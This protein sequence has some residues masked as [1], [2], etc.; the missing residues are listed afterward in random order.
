[1]DSHDFVYW[2]GTQKK[3]EPT[4]TFSHCLSPPCPFP[5]LCRLKLPFH[6]WVSVPEIRS[7]K[8]TLAGQICLIQNGQPMRSKPWGSRK[9]VCKQRRNN[10]ALRL[11]SPLPGWRPKWKPA[12][13]WSLQWPTT[14][15]LN[16][17]E[18][19]TMHT[20]Q[21]APRC[22]AMYVHLLNKTSKW[23]TLCP[24]P[25]TSTEEV[26][27][28]SDRSGEEYDASKEKPSIEEPD[29]NEEDKL[30]DDSSDEA[31]NQNKKRGKKSAHWQLQTSVAVGLS[32]GRS[33]GSNK[34]AIIL[35]IFVDVDHLKWCLCLCQ[36]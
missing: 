35:K 6:V 14:P 8:N 17:T 13:R 33:Q 10:C 25:R 30:L 21:G 2:H 5:P 7:H 16:H 12:R 4:W 19:G 11:S 23:T 29:E 22:C 20:C 34:I 31:L 9:P 18:E 26:D 24:D 28:T 3:I 27:S 32:A 15:P 36:H 1:M